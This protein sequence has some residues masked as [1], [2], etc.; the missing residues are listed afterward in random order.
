MAEDANNTVVDDELSSTSVNPVQN[1]AV[2]EALDDKA[3]SEHSHSASDITSGY[4]PL[5]RGGLGGGTAT[6]SLYNLIANSIQEFSDTDISGIYVAL[7]DAYGSSTNPILKAVTPANFAA[8]IATRITPDDIGALSKTGNR[9][10]RLQTSD[11]AHDQ[12]LLAL[13]MVLPSSTDQA[14]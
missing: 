12:R 9:C 1:K 2:K 3:N 4:L 6:A 14:T 11:Q 8:G 13:L 5:S 7:V 10:K